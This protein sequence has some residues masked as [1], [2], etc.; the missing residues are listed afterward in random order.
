MAQRTGTRPSHGS[1]GPAPGIRRGK[2]ARPT[3]SGHQPGPWVAIASAGI[4]PTC[5]SRW[6]NGRAGSE[7]K[8]ESAETSLVPF[9]PGHIARRCRRS[10]RHEQ[11][12][13]QADEYRAGDT[14]EPQPGPFM[15]A[16]PLPDGA[17]KIA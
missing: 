5:G 14:V 13:A 1:S 2:M 15:P 17:S 11:L 16:Q 7:F 9:D 10:A 12:Q 6:S 8:P 3:I 4:R